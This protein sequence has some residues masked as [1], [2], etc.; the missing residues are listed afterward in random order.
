M[1]G[2][3]KN[4]LKRGISVALAAA[5]GMTTLATGA[6]AA[7]SGI[8]IGY[9]WDTSVN[10]HISVKKS[11]KSGGVEGQYIKAGEQICR[12][13]PSSGSDWAV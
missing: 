12:F 13:V 9:T 6:S 8:N 10:P 2:K 7:T 4:I 5:I 11:A 1:N 3:I